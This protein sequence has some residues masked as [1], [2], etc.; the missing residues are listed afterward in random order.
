VPQI[1]TQYIVSLEL[2]LE[3]VSEIQDALIRC[4]QEYALYPE[5]ELKVLM[6]TLYYQ[7][8]EFFE[9]SARYLTG[10]TFL[11]VVRWERARVECKKIMKLS[12]RIIKEAEYFNRREVR[13]INK[14]VLEVDRK[15]DLVMRALEE[16]QR[17]LEAL[18]EEEKVLATISDHQQV[19]QALQQ[20]LA[21][22]PPLREESSLVGV[23]AETTTVH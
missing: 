20:L 6:S 7:A 14:R 18:R 9:T 13:E 21:R 15:Q 11:V 12:N 3:A 4:E 23:V 1:A 5:P 17:A 16:Q 10:P 8:L 22:F 19:L 2:L